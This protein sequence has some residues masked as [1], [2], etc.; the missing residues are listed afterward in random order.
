M[1][2]GAEG[3]DVRE[4]DFGVVQGHDFGSASPEVLASMANMP[5]KISDIHPYMVT[6][7]SLK[8]DYI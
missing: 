1:Y 8:Y 5:G 4:A 6:N 7:T 3:T 2:E